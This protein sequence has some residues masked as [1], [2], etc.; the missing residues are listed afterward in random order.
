MERHQWA[1]LLLGSCAQ[2][3]AFTLVPVLLTVALLR[4][5]RAF[6]LRAFKRKGTKVFYNGHC[7][8]IGEPV[9]WGHLSAHY[10]EQRMWPSRFGGS[11]Y[12]T[13]EEGKPVRYEVSVEVQ[14]FG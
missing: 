3:V 10:D 13:V 7:I 14:E 9:W 8:S 2:L 1:Q 5:I 11:C 6:V 4:I 12:E